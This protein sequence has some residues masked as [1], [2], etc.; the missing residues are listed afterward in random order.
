MSL[1]PD[2]V[3]IRTQVLGGLPSWLGFG[4]LTPPWIKA[5]LSSHTVS[6]VYVV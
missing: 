3:A 6:N 5:A 1:G 2:S 4:E